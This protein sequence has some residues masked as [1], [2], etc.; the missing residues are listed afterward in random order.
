LVIESFCKF[1]R[2][3]ESTHEFG[4]YYLLK[5][6][7]ALEKYDSSFIGNRHRDAAEFLDSLMD[8]VNF[9]LS[10]DSC[11]E[12]FKGCEN[13]LLTKECNCPCINETF[14]K[15]GLL[16]FPIL[17]QRR[18]KLHLDDLIEAYTAPE[19]LEARIKC[20]NGFG[21]VRATQRFEIIP[22]RIMVIQLKRFDLNKYG[23]VKN[24]RFVK[25][26]LEEFDPTGSCMIY[27][28]E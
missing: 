12:E 15:S 7:K 22:A 10:V 8:A 20:H 16:C 27:V 9:S 6:K 2:K 23:N 24:E 13:A 28:L 14:E 1:I 4:K 17:S 5:L 3:F 18:G 11:F 25:F 26:P 21:V 19:E